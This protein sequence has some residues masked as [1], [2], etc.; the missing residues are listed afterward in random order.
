MNPFFAFRKSLA[1]GVNFDEKRFDEI[2]RN[3]LARALVEQAK[4]KGKKVLIVD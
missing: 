1:S 4:K 3:Y 2:E